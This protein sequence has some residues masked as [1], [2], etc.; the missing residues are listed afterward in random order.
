[1]NCSDLDFLPPPRLSTVRPTRALE[2]TRCY[3]VGHDQSQTSSSQRQEANSTDN[4]VA[5]SGDNGLIIS[6]GTLHDLNITSAD[7]GVASDGLTAAVALGAQSQRTARDLG[8]EAFD[9]AEALGATALEG[10]TTYVDGQNKFVDHALSAVQNLTAN[11]N[12][13]AANVAASQADFVAAATG[14]KTDKTAF[15]VAGGV[16]AIA[17]VAALAFSSKSK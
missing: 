17:A 11:S 1:M 14:Q 13:I 15:M 5:L 10:L 16:L 4:R 9:T 3:C 6:Q 8:A 7:A 2:H 12:Q